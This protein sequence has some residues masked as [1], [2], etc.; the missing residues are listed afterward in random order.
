VILESL[1]RFVFL[2]RV[3]HLSNKMNKTV[4]KHVS[5][6]SFC[7]IFARIYLFVFPLGN[8]EGHEASESSRSISSI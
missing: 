2:P 6:K 1:K 8:T 3:R 4:L 7:N 5:S